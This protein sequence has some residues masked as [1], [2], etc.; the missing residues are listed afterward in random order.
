MIDN[1]LFILGA[2]LALNWILPWLFSFLY[3]QVLKLSGDI[4]LSHKVGLTSVYVLV[5][6]ESWYAK[7]WSDWLGT[8]LFMVVIYR[9]SS[10]NVDPVVIT[11]ELEHCHQWMKYGLFFVVLYFGHFS[12]ILATQKLKG[13]PYTRHPYYDNWA[14]VA[15]RKKAGQLVT[16]PPDRWR[17][18]PF[19]LNPWLFNPT[20]E[21]IA[22]DLRIWSTL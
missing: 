20:K 19:D 1:P 18:G 7:L 17:Q 13:E 15:A 9:K 2:A 5:S 11:H 8:G 3:V 10:P 14:E 22:R 4:K 12:L 16:I 21:E 6:K